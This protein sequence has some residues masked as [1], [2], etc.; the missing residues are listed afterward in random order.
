MKARR[1]ERLAVIQMWKEVV[2]TCGRILQ[3]LFELRRRK[4]CPSDAH[5]HA[6]LLQLAPNVDLLHAVIQS[7][8]WNSLR[9]AVGRA[10]HHV[11]NNLCPAH[12]TTV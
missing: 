3:Q 8:G 9:R 1:H 7:R 4:S 10:L 11:D 12:R 2:R 6:E 5:D